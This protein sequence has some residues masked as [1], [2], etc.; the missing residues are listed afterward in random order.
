MW[1]PNKNICLGLAALLASAHF[2][3]A[4]VKVGQAFP[5]LANFELEG[6]LPEGTGRVM[7][8]DF[9]A[10][11]CAPCKAS[12]PSYSQLQRELGPQGFTLIAVSVDKQ[13]AA[14]QDFLKKHAPDFAT[15]R[16]GKQKLAAELRVPGMPT[17]Y[18]VDRQ[19]VLRAVHVGFHG[20]A[21]ERELHEQIVRLLAEKP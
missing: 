10:S 16:D 9:W 20:E 5:T 19:G 1:L 13:A 15:V 7:L 17:S 14:Y 2:L 18:L 21:T 8:V 12:F 4:E 6:R 11:W 3:T